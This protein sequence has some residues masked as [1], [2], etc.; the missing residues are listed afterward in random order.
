MNFKE[1]CYLNIY[2]PKFI[3]WSKNN[4]YEVSF[5]ARQITIFNDLKDFHQSSLLNKKE[6]I[7]FPYTN[8]LIYDERKLYD[9]T[10]ELID[11]IKDNI[12]NIKINNLLFIKWKKIFKYFNYSI[13]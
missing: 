1:Y 10:Y 13:I 12:I 7:D 2:I 11:H 3:N 4:T 9:D 8:E 6:E 5:L